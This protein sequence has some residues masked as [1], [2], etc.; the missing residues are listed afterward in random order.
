MLSSTLSA[1]IIQFTLICWSSDRQNAQTFL[2]YIKMNI[3]HLF[4]RDTVFSYIHEDQMYVEDFLSLL[5]DRNDLH[6]SI[7]TE[8]TIFLRNNW[9]LDFL[10]LSVFSIDKFRC[11]ST[12]NNIMPS[13]SVWIYPYPHRCE[14][15]CF[16]RDLSLLNAHHSSSYHDVFSVRILNWF[17]F[18]VYF[19]QQNRLRCFLQC[20]NRIS[21]GT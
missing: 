11:L 21:K 5:H 18:F 19:V 9:P 20:S 16:V 4:L 15:K 8:V 14:S 17:F 6:C 10:F 7:T 12:D 1:L 3:C 13:E 2:L